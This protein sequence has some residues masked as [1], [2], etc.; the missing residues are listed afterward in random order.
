MKKSFKICLIFFFINIITAS[1][2]SG[3]D[4]KLRIISLAPST[5]EI[6][7]AL[8]LDDEIIGV[9]QY[10]NYPEQALNKTKIGTFSQPNIEK[11]LTLKPDIIFCTGLE[12]APAIDKLKK[13]NLKV[14]VCDPRNF[15]ELF[16]SIK[17]IAELTGKENEGKALIQKM[18]NEIKEIS[19]KTQVMPDDKKPKVFIEIW[20]RPLMT[21]GAGSFVDELVSIAGGANIAKDTLRPYS[22]FSAEEV[23][24]RDPD[25]IILAYMEYQSSK[26]ALYQRLGWK[27]ISAVKNNRV[28][29]D[30]DPD[31]FLRPGPRITEGLRRLYEK[32]HNDKNAE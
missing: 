10:C 30:I 4:K 26:K 28:Y 15:R 29:N 31:L 24:K 9:S 16:A 25:C 5:T 27:N 32:L 3:A 2:V 6:L 18:K 12:Q 22:Y 1:A 21:A 23:I 11:I 7:F 19:D 14:Y 20:S 17:E 13:L 8:G